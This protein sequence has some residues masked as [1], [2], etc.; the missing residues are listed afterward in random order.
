M[1]TDNKPKEEKISLSATEEEYLETLFNF[2]EC[3]KKIV[4]TSEVSKSMSVSPGTV[5]S[6]FKRLAEKN[7]IYYRSH[8][9]A[10]LTS[11]G[12]KL[13]ATVVRKHRLAEIWLNDLGVPFDILHDLACEFEHVISDD[14]ADLI[15]KRFNAKNCPHGNPMPNKDGSIS[16]KDNYPIYSVS[17]GETVLIEKIVEPFCDLIP[18]SMIEKLKP[19][20]VL[21]IKKINKDK[22]VDAL[23]NNEEIIIPTSLGRKLFVSMK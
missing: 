2:L 5:T 14:L 21:Q 16:I 17:P 6:M 10:E 1:S 4:R 13:S 8:Y 20:T 22:S 23:L 18:R 12:R 19:G 3:G 15:E 9:G 7:L 11:L